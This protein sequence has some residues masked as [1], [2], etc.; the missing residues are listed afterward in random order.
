MEHL[1]FYF[2]NH[3]FINLKPIIFYKNVGQDKTE[4]FQLSTLHND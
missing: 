2:L 1:I 4:T 3:A